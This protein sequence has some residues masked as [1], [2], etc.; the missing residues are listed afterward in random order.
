MRAM[1]RR[2]RFASWAIAGLLLLPGCSST[3]TETAAAPSADPNELTLDDAIEECSRLIASV[4]AAAGFVDKAGT[5][6]GQQGKDE[7][8]ATAQALESINRTILSVPY[9][10]PD[11]Q[12]L[13]G[14]YVSI[15]QTRAVITRELG[16]AYKRNDKDAFTKTSAKLDALGKQEDAV[17]EEINLKC[18]GRSGEEPSSGSAP[19]APA[20]APAPQPAPTPAPAS[21]A[22]P[23]PPLPAPLPPPAPFPSPSA[24]GSAR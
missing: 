2:M 8:E 24:S 4:N 5:E 18:R 3:S 10:I 16:A 15:L 7:F 12:R 20:P 19:S 21:A 14:F 17:V 6:A 1:K 23:P 11:M 9:R 13:S 22:A